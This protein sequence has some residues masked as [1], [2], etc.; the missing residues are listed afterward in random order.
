MAL[1]LEVLICL[2]VLTVII[3]IYIVSSLN[4]NFRSVNE[5]LSPVDERGETIIVLL[6][7][8]DRIL[9]EHKISMD[10]L[11]NALDGIQNKNNI[12]RLKINKQK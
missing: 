5:L 2:S 7:D 1:G 8:F 4:L 11:L 12:I 9:S 3:Y 10:E 6:E